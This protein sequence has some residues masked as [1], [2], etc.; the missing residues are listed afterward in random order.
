M[1]RDAVNHSWWLPYEPVGLTAAQMHLGFCIAM[2]LIDG[3]VFVD[4][5]TEENMGRADLLAFAKRVDCVRDEAR[6]KKG[7][8]FARGA[9][10]EVQLKD[11]RVIRKVVDNFLGSWQKPMSDEQMAQKYRRLAAKSLAPESVKELERLVRAME[12][13]TSVE[14]LVRILAGGTPQAVATHEQAALA[15]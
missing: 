1:T 4:Q 12:S 13:Q 2:K 5:M 15:E 9:D 11:G 10:V 8:P 6:E 3:E 14:R 7:R